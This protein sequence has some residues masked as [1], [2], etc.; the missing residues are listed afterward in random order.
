MPDGCVW[1]AVSRTPRGRWVI[2]SSDYVHLRVS[3]YR[4][5]FTAPAD[6]LSF[7]E[8]SAGACVLEADE[9]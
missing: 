6:A 1:L 2:K 3:D 9:C 7:A 4:R 5:R 8:S